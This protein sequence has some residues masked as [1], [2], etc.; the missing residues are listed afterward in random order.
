[1]D[2]SERLRNES[3]VKIPR[4]IVYQGQVFLRILHKGVSKDIPLNQD[5]RRRKSR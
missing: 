5:N 1:M 4:L 2:R 3:A